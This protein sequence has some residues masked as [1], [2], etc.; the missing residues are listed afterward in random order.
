MKTDSDKK[1]IAKS[2]SLFGGLQGL[3][4]LSGLVRNKV[5][6]I[7][8][9]PAGMGLI[10]LYNNIVTLLNNVSNLGISFS[11]V[12]HI[13]ELYEEGNREALLRYITVVRGWTIISSL[14]GLAC[15]VSL[16]PLFS[17]LLFNDLYHSIH[18]SLLSLA[19]PFGIVSAVEMGIL[20]GVRKIREMAYASVAMV[21]VSL[22]VVLPMYYFLGMKGVM[23]SIVAMGFITMAAATHFS[24]QEF[25]VFVS[26]KI[27]ETTG[28]ERFPWYMGKAENTVKIEV[29]GVIDEGKPMIKLGIA[30][31]V[32]MC[33]TS[34]TEVCLRTALLK[35]ADIDTVG[36]YNAGYLI[37]VNY[38]G[39]VFSAIES[40]YFPRLSAVNKDADRFNKVVNNQAFVSLLIISPGIIAFMFLM[41]W[42]LQ[43][44]FSERFLVITGMLQ[45]AALNLYLRSVTLPVAYLN[46]AKGESRAYLILEISYDIFF[47]ASMLIGYSLMGLTGTGLAITFSAIFDFIIV[48]AWCSLK[49]GF[50]LEKKVIITLIINILIGLA[51]YLFVSGLVRI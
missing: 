12:K 14:F 27:R 43:L 13:S 23:P 3:S 39:M 33:A 2:I 11:A 40:D 19:V 8:L 32:G 51:V 48:V 44:L 49:Y 1:H 17:Y 7:L 35:I 41:P 26:Q 5:V 47:L 31:V 9:G 50:R 36:L 46:L 29:R 42:C 38:A 28:I 45:L 10:S 20:K 21:V 22:I 24:F 15:G 18:I 37:V 30:F 6:A 4:I 16:S 34:L 25:P